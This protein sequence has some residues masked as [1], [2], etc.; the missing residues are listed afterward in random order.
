MATWIQVQFIL[1]FEK[2]LEA[3]AWDDE[4]GRARKPPSK[5]LGI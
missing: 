5:A 1:G 4:L 3:V 2:D